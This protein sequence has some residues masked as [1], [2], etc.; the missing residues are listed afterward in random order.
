MMIVLRRT[1]FVAFSFYTRTAEE[2][3]ITALTQT[4]YNWFK[5]TKGRGLLRKKEKAHVSVPLSGFSILDF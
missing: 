4:P 5:V 1:T 3:P 2:L